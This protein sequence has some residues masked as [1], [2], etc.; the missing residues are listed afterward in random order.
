MAKKA[1]RSAAKAKQIM[2]TLAIGEE[3]VHP[4]TLVYGEEGS[5][6][7][8]LLGEE[9]HPTTL[10]LGEEGIH[11]TTILLGEEHIHT[12][13][14]LGEEGPSNPTAE[15]P[16]NVIAEQFG[17]II[18]PGGPVERLAAVA[19]GQAARRKKKR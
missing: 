7:T 14:L 16:S 19:K 18:D 13:V 9:L 10:H 17:P 4:T 15:H 6:T 2:T 5:P 11:P 1:R 3:G 8:H 12:T